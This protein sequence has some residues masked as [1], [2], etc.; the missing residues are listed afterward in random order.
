[1]A[2]ERLEKALP[3]YRRRYR[4]ARRRERSMVLDESCGL[5][6]HH[7]KYAIALLN[8]PEDAGGV[9]VRRIGLVELH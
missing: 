2:G 4:E 7:R 9:R 6:G 5:T 1:M 3:K 8:R